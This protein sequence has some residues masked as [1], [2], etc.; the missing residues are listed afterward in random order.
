[1][2]KENVY[3]WNFLEK[4]S[5]KTRTGLGYAAGLCERIFGNS[6]LSSNINSPEFPFQLW[7]VIGDQYNSI[8]EFDNLF[9][10]L[11]DVQDD[12]RKDYEKELKKIQGLKKEVQRNQ[13][14]LEILLSSD[15]CVHLGRMFTELAIRLSKLDSRMDS[16][17]KNF[18]E[19]DLKVISLS[20]GTIE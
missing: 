7:A 17:D 16:L 20:G 12:I 3:N 1:M 19:T 2:S 14:E 9:Q 18:K 8:V 13:K 10:K 6:S 11:F 5:P 4:K 15:D